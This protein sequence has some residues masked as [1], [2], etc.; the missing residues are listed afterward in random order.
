MAAHPSV[1]WVGVQV[2]P[3]G[4]LATPSSR[5]HVKPQPWIKTRDDSN[6]KT[7]SSPH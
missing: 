3:H 6:V 1:I 5:N 7:M 4:L 2:L